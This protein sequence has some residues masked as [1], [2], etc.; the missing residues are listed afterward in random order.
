MISMML[1]ISLF[2][3]IST[4]TFTLVW[5]IISKKLRSYQKLNIIF[6]LDNTLIM[7]LETRKYLRMKT[8]HK[9]NLFITNHVVW[10]RPWVR[11]V[12]WL[13]NKFCNLYLFTRADKI[14]AD[15]ILL[16][17][18]IKDYFKTCK[19]RF[20]CN[21]HTKDIRCLSLSYEKLL[22]YCLKIK[23]PIFNKEDKKLIRLHNSKLEKFISTAILV[24]DKNTNNIKGQHFYHINF[25]Q[26]GMV[27]DWE[28]I[29]LLGWVC[30]KSIVGLNISD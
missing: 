3:S 1:K 10:L 17:F 20:D 15:D 16:G 27:W 28:I 9:P 23:T 13:M 8:Q 26:F 21:T 24:D 30:W 2:I 5:W 18:G 11:E 6:D 12:L 19:Y 29:K 25:Y 4:F 22:E 7:S 14:Y